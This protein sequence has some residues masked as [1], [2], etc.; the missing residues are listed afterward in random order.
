MLPIPD[1][2]PDN[3]LHIVLITSKNRMTH[4]PPHT[5]GITITKHL[6]SYLRKMNQ[7]IVM[8]YLGTGVVRSLAQ[9]HRMVALVAG[10]Q[11]DGEGGVGGPVDRCDV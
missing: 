6:Q 4:I 11:G 10:G 1:C 8:M 2:S 7:I 3:H 9:Q 5:K